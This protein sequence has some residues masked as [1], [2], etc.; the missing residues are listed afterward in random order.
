MRSRQQRGTWLIGVIAAATAL[1][2]GPATGEAQK[3]G[4][5]EPPHTGPAQEKKPEYG[6][7]NG[8]SC[9]F[10]TPEPYGGQLFCPVT[11][12]KLGVRQPAVPVQ[13]TLGE[14]QPNFLGKLFG[15]KP[16][17]G[18]VI[19]VCS[20]E[21]ADKVRGNPEFFFSEVLADKACFTF[22][23]ATAPAQ[24]PER[25]RTE[26]AAPSQSNQAPLGN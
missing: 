8:G 24:R 5:S 6:V 19:Y 13:T 21:C 14:R 18:A 26:V 12:M 9:T 3:Y 1:L 4:G 23:Y 11:G 10:A 16:K 25:A 22:T 17:P 7:G 2:L 15:Q 20:P